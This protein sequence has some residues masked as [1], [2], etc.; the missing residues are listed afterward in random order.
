[1][2]NLISVNLK[3]GLGNYLFQ[4][5]CAYNYSIKYNKH[6]ILDEKTAHVVHNK[7]E[8]YK[9][10][11]FQHLEFEH[12]SNESIDYI[13]QEKVFNYIE[14][15]K[16]NKN[17]LL[18]GYFQSERYFEKNKEQIKILFE[19]AEEIR[20]DIVVKFPF[21]LNEKTCSI[22]VRRGDYLKA[23][24]C[25]PAQ[26]LN[27][28]EKAIENFDTDTLFLIFSDDI[29]WC[30]K[31]FS[32]M[33]KRLIYIEN[34]TDFEDLYLMSFCNNNIICNST[35]SWWGAWLNNNQN[36]KI[37]APEKWFGP[38]LEN[39]TKDLYCKEWIKI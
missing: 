16:I 19:C 4:I 10:N 22:H 29:E 18:D 30:K 6:L 33:D 39:N 28:Y 11:I 24:N 7:I 9:K 15:P 8:T 32:K 20:N 12:L 1:M 2:E 36:K 21:I 38:Q 26:T 27:Y 17:L 31:E 5:A 14:I 3:G 34:N 35:F 37:I 23:P 25:H 13:Y